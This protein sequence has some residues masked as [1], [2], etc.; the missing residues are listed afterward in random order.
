LY[1]VQ[2][3]FEKNHNS[4][5]NL[6]KLISNQ[7]RFIN[8]KGPVGHSQCKHQ[9]STAVVSNKVIDSKIHTH[10]KR[11]RSE[12]LEYFEYSAQHFVNKD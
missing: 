9:D 10:E 4:A 5:K 11:S 2:Q 1:V 6:Q 8:A 12:L 7:I 3:W